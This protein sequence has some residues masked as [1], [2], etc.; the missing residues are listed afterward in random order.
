LTYFDCQK[1]ELVNDEDCINI[2]KL[3]GEK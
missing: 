1:F 2:R 3:Q